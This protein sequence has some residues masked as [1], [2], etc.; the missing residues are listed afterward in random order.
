MI[1]EV[2]GIC[3][4][5]WTGYELVN[6]RADY[7]LFCTVTSY[8]GIDLADLM[9]HCTYSGGYHPSQPYIQVGLLVYGLPGSYAGV[10]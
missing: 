5:I 9:K 4:S 1:R 7:Y 8:T 10:V 6:A 2:C 3:S